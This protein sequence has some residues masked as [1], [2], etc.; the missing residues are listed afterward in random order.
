MAPAH[1]H[2][3]FDI[4]NP[5]TGKLLTAVAAAQKADVDSAVKAAQAALRPTWKVTTAVQRARL[6]NKLADIVEREA[7]IFAATE[8]V[9]AGIVQRL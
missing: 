2:D 6:L 1:T 7:E 5:A 3:I 8:A 4:I 9:D